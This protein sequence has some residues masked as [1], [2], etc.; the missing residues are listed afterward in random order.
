[1]A[2]FCRGDVIICPSPPRSKRLS[3]RDSPI[4]ESSHGFPDLG[5]RVKDIASC[6]MPYVS[7]AST[8]LSPQS[9]P[10]DHGLAIHGYEERERES[11]SIDVNKLPSGRNMLQAWLQHSVALRSARESKAAPLPLSGLSWLAATSL[12]T[13]EA[14]T[15]THCIGAS[16]VR[17]VVSPFI[18][19]LASADYGRA[20]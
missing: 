12:M 14:T 19:S 3:T 6:L 10:S 9:S 20:F 13:L 16:L 17:K 2:K 5:Q 7:C 15:A 4:H 8:L 1:M 18:P 11:D